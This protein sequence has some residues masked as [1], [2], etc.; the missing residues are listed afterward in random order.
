MSGGSFEYMYIRI[1]EMYKGYLK[2]KELEELLD[3]FCQVLKELEWYESCDTSEEDYR[4]EVMRFKK[5]W[6]SGYDDN[7]NGRIDRFKANFREIVEQQ[8]S[9]I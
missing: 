5:K 6:L 9:Q 2:D 3:D 1:E 8:L 4:K 7:T